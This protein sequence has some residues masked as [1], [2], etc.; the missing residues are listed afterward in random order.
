VFKRAGHGLLIVALLCATGGH[1]AVWQS[2]A[3]AAMLANNARAQ[4]LSMAIEQTFDG[5]H[6]CPI[7]RQIAK[8]RQSEKKSDAQ[9]ELKKL[10]FLLERITFVISAPA[11]YFL[12]DEPL[13]SAPL[14]N[15]TPPTPPPR[16]LPA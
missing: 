5:K 3:W 11:H 14:L 6:P 8:A 2:V 16:E 10:E 4:S 9:P 15:H 1:W 12:L 13:Q 7:C